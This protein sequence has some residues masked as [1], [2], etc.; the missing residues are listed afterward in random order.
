MKNPKVLLIFIR[1]PMIGKVKK[2][3]LKDCD[4]IFIT[5][6]YKQFIIDLLSTIKK[7][8]IE[9]KICFYPP[10]S[11]KNIISLFGNNYQ[12][13]PQKG[14]NLGE[15]MKNSFNKVFKEGYKNVVL[16]GSDI[17]DLPGDFIL[18]S[19]DFLQLNDVVIGPSRDG[20]YYLIGLNKDSFNALIFQDII[21]SSESVF[22]DTIK[23]LN[24]LTLTVHILPEWNDIDTIDDLH[25][26][27]NRNQST[28]FRK[29]KTMSLLIKYQNMYK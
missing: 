14:N 27:Y 17:P 4:R 8:N 16:I 12:Y 1:N 2:R 21:W 23:I 22:N 18:K 25:D 9:F 19:F 13:I 29:S 26:L 24:K 15:R 6:L 7:L 10:D 28:N 3:L 11:E 20:G 5:V